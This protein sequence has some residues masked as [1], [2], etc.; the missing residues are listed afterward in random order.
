MRLSV[1]TRPSQT[2]Q[3][4]GPLGRTASI[5]CGWFSKHHCRCDGALLSPASALPVHYMIHCC[6]RTLERS[7]CKHMHETP[8]MDG[9]VEAEQYSTRHARGGPLS[10]H[11]SST[12][13]WAGQ[14]G[15]GA[16]CL[17]GTCLPALALPEGGAA[18]GGWCARLRWLARVPVRVS[19]EEGRGPRASQ[20][21]APARPP[22][23]RAG[24][25]RT[26]SPQAR[27][28]RQACASSSSSSSRAAN[29]Q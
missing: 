29:D 15:V 8:V 11:T 5:A 20:C 25:A 9:T 19:A 7:Q 13:A 24:R 23:T 17:G 16:S 27:P 6:T 1:A 14:G 10:Y 21:C 26:V 22:A 3:P 4:P 18:L 28:L 12:S 2:C